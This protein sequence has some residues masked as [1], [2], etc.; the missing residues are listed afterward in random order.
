MDDRVLRALD[1]WPN[2]PAVF[3]WL[4]LDMRGRWRLDGSVIRNANT[5]D[6]INRNYDHDDDGQ[7]FYQNGPQRVYVDLAY[8]PWVYRLD[9]SGALM[10]HTSLPVEHLEQV[11]LD[12]AHH[13]LLRSE[14]GIGVV[15]DQDLAPMLDRLLDATG[16]VMEW[17]D[18]E[19]QMQS[20]NRTSVY[21][22]WGKMHD[23]GRIERDSVAETFG[24]VARPRSTTAKGI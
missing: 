11:W 13:L 8:T 23:V 4:A 9:G 1:K 5:N 24:F 20:G 3:G 7:W 17:E 19:C 14:W 16:A 6:A 21:L 2:V 10:T 15:S 18:L 22:H 12:E